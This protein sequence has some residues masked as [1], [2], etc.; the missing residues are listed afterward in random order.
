MI[1][2]RYVPG[3]FPI[4]LPGGEGTWLSSAN[5]SISFSTDP[6]WRT[7]IE[8]IGNELA[9]LNQ[10]DDKLMKQTFRKHEWKVD[11]PVD[12]IGLED[13][14]GRWKYDAYKNRIAV[15]VELSRRSQVFKDVFKFLIGQAMSQVEIGIVM[16][17]RNLIEKGQPHLGSVRRDSHAFYH[18]LPMLKMAF[19][20]FP[21]KIEG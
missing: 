13:K 8:E 21:N 20:G 9:N 4:E 1:A 3:F 6:W 18:T 19:Y 15:E 2:S 7:E 5:L 11:E 14:R 12:G 16:V 10:L 17:P